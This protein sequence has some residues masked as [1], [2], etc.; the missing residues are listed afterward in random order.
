MSEL[1]INQESL[2]NTI[3]KNGQFVFGFNATNTGEIISS[4]YGAMAHGVADDGG[5]IANGEGS[6][7]EGYAKIGSISASGEGSHAEGC[8]I[9]GSISASGEGSHAE[10]VNTHAYAKASHA[11]G[12]GT[13]ANY[14]AMTAI[15]KYNVSINNDDMLFAIGNGVFSHAPAYPLRM[16]ALYVKTT[17]I[18]PEDNCLTYINGSLTVTK[19]VSCNN[20]YTTNGAYQISDITKKDI[21][22]KDISLEK[23]YSVLEKCH[24][25][26]YNLKDDESKKEQIGMIAQEI[27]DYFPEIIIKSKDEI[28]SLDYSKLSVILFRLCQDLIKKN[29]EINQRL[30]IIEEK[31]N[32]L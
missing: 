17:G 10:G 29:Q 1:K 27:Q 7:A 18:N 30:N 8:A 6:H 26:L 15:G 21:I 32:N 5:I 22:L 24:T 23:V 28:L 2:E 13:I 25:I 9:D 14:E 31:L 16:N 19:D 12:I 20:L 3:L 4:S 11:S